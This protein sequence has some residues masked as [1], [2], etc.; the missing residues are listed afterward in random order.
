[1]EENIV[2]SR[3]EG[4]DLKVDIFHPDSASGQA[5]GLLFLPGGGWR[6][7]DRTPLK[8]RYGVRMAQR[9]IL[10]VAGEYRVMDEASWPAQIQ[11]VK[12]IIQWMRAN[13]RGWVLTH[14]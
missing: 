5:P 13:S 3:P 9:G 6:T 10:C 7:A 2:V 11:D 1:M 12:A 8:D 4:R 14:P